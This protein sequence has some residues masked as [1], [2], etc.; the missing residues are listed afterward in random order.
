MADWISSTLTF[1]DQVEDIVGIAI[2]KDDALSQYLTNGAREVV[3]RVVAIRP[4][5]A[6]QFADN[7]VSAASTGMA[8]A[9]VSTDILSVTLGLGTTLW[10]DVKPATGEDSTD[11]EWQAVS[12][13]WVSTNYPCDRID[14]NEANE[15]Y[16]PQSLKYRTLYNAGW[17]MR[18]G[19]IL[20]TPTPGGGTSMNVTFVEYPIV[21][22]TFTPET[23][24]VFVDGE[25][26]T[27]GL[28]KFP[29]QYSYLISLYAATRVLRNLISAKTLPAVPVA[30]GAPTISYAAASLGDT[31]G[32]LA[33]DSIAGAVDGIAGSVEGYTGETDTAM[34]G[35][36]A[37]GT[38]IG[39]TGQSAQNA[40]A[41][42]TGTE[43]GTLLQMQAGDA[44]DAVDQIGFDTWWEH[45]GDLI[46]T[47]ED[48]ELAQVQIGK[49]NSYITAF[50]AEVA[51]ASA[52]MQ[53]TIQDA[54]LATQANIA[55][56]QADV[57]IKQAGM[58]SKTSAQTAKMQ[59]ATQAAI[60]KMNASTGAATAKMNQS[61]TA[62]I[63]KMTQ[64]TNLN[65]TNAAK[66]LEAAMGDYQME[67][68][69]FTAE[70]QNYTSSVNK[71][72]TEYQW[73][74]EQYTSVRREYDTA[75]ASLVT[76]E[77]SIKTSIMDE[78]KVA[79]ARPSAKVI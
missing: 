48:S 60:A 40:D 5:K 31:F 2:A 15:A 23:V 65:I 28:E 33:Q 27:K 74:V 54:Q 12:Y 20:T 61:T 21:Q 25:E 38:G 44:G 39:Y 57:S 14:H 70:I 32:G 67:I 42:G 71:A 36:A 66:T 69:R 10:E 72:N 3:T 30:P 63:Q 76:P 77:Q 59:S 7:K 22:H 1:G 58:G 29:T 13:D 17:F 79:Q 8:V 9:D 78:Q 35:S 6:M 34:T 52:A 26:T 68:A 64:S 45:L 19:R 41:G 53:A 4:E 37:K 49:I 24:T 55:T 51:D 11:Y 62:A 46:E 56:H 50:Q 43:N 18:N 47:E 75:F 16:N 73:L